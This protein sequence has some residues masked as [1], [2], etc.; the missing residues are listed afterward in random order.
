MQEKSTTEILQALAPVTT[1]RH[2]LECYQD[3]LQKVDTAHQIWVLQDT[4]DRSQT[5]KITGE[6]DSPENSIRETGRG[7]GLLTENDIYDL[8]DE[9][10]L[11]IRAAFEKRLTE[12]KAECE[13]LL[14]ANTFTEKEGKDE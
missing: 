12:L 10:R 14:P 2:R 1:A 9:F 6:W 7:F 4:R 8:A 11:L 3:I 5:L 13:A